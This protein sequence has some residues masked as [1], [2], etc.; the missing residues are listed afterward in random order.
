VDAQFYPTSV[1][2]AIATSGNLYPAAFCTNTQP[3]AIQSFSV[4]GRVSSFLSGTFTT[5]G[6]SGQNTN[7]LT[8][9][10]VAPVC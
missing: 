2:P 10:A 6:S 8:G 1:G 5:V 4:L 3:L 7:S 9:A